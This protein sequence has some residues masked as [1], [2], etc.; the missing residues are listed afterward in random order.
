MSNKSLRITSEALNPLY[1]MSVGF[2]RFVEDFFTDPVFTHG[3]GSPTGYPP[4]NINK[5]V[6]TTTTETEYE[7]VL[8]LAGFTENDIEICVENN[9]LKIMGTSGCLNTSDNNSDEDI[10]YLHKGIAERSF[11]RTFKLADYVEVKKATLKD[12]I[13]RIR[14]WR[15]VPEAAKPK[16]IA[17]TSQ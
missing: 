16:K 5:I 11:N 9:N 17:V 1:R 4:F 8:A 14:L 12:G 7:V 3:S 2:D 6:N 10:H 15:D 13:L